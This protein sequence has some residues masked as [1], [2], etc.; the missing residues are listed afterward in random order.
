MQ[1]TLVPFQC[2]GRQRK[3]QGTYNMPF[4]LCGLQKLVGDM[5]NHRNY[6]RIMYIVKGDIVGNR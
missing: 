5:F 1:P 3:E 6:L 2:S 4:F